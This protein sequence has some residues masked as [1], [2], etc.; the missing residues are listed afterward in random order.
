M[1]QI[2]IIGVKSV[3]WRQIKRG[4]GIYFLLCCMSV[5]TFGQS[6]ENWTI[7]GR[8]YLGK[9]IKHNP[10]IIFDPPAISH[11]HELGIQFQT[12]GKRAWQELQGYPK[13]GIAFSYFNLGDRDTVGYAYAGRYNITLNVMQ[14]KQWDIQFEFGGGLAWLDRP[15]NRMSNPSNNAIG[16]SINGFA[17]INFI[18]NYHL[19][20]HWS[21][22][23]GLGLTHYSNGAAQLPNLGINITSLMIGVRYAP[24]PL[25]EENYIQ[26][27]LSKQTDQHYGFRLEYM[28][29]FR[30]SQTNGGPRYPI[31]T[32]SLAGR[33]SLNKINRAFLGL[34]YEYNKVVYAFGTAVF[35]FNSEKEA[36]W[37]ASRLSI[38]VEDEFLF[39]NLGIAL[40][41]GYYLGDFSYLVPNSVYFKISHR[42]YFRF[43]KQP[44][45][46]AFAGITLKTH[47]SVAEHF[48]LNLGLDF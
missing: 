48:A 32:Y 17:Q 25:G 41:A 16:S 3:V 2:R 5:S 1:F 12:Y 28:I 4:V 20:S 30:E 13:V 21:L 27:G 46:R 37:G 36:F 44:A 45:I 24:K 8:S 42:C 39:G 6:I 10:D 31:R 40:Q 14:R 7:N 38:F 18:T 23:S 19:D 33:Y 26:A 47:F 15:F 35:A 29:G 22:F 11:G 9:I 43:V 34:T